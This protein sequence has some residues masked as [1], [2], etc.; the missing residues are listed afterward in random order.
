MGSSLIGRVEKHQGHIR[1]LTWGNSGGERTC[2]A[3]ATA[4][5]LTRCSLA[6]MGEIPN[7]SSLVN[8]LRHEWV[9]WML[10][11][12]AELM[13]R[14][15]YRIHERWRLIEG[16]A[17]RS[18]R[19]K[20]TGAKNSWRSPA[21]WLHDCTLKCATVTTG[22]YR[23][24]GHVPWISTACQTR[25]TATGVNPGA[26]ITGGEGDWT[27]GYFRYCTIRGCFSCSNRAFCSAICFR[28]YVVTWPTLC[29]KV[30]VL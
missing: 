20:S 1:V 28:F 21:Q 23:R 14:S 7:W 10:E 3:L 5:S 12:L 16:D 27:L 19:G 13:A 11:Y 2:R 30:V 18:E 9:R 15:I 17:R 24:S 26:R 29:I 25:I 22:Q 6:D 8:N 4:S